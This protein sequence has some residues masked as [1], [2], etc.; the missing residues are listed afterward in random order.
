M[1]YPQARS[2]VLLSALLFLMARPAVANTV[3]SEILYDA[4]DGDNGKVFVELF[5]E[6]GSAL[7]GLVVE[8]IN[9]SS[10]DVTHSVGAERLDVIR[11]GVRHR[12]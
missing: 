9:G 12:R 4:S 10:G 7:D 5:G 6:P 3:I 8:G 2:G 1:F 11:W